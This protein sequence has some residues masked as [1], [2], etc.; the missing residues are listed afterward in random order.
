MK[1]VNQII[2][3][4]FWRLALL[5]LI[6]V[7]AMPWESTVTWL[8]NRPN[9]WFVALGIVDLVLGMYILVRVTVWI[10]YGSFRKYFQKV[11]K[12]QSEL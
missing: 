8:L 3:A 6:Y 10:C 9:T 5:F 2:F 4:V 11:E 12:G 1:T 7:V